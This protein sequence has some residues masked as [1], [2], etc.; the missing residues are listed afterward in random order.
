MFKESYNIEGQTK[1]APRTRKAKVNLKAL[2]EALM[3]G[4]HYP[5]T[6]GDRYSKLGA[7]FDLLTNC[8]HLT[9][10]FPWNGRTIHLEVGSTIT[11][12]RELAENWRWQV[13][14]VHSF[15]KTLESEG[16][17]T[18]ESTKDGTVISF[19]GADEWDND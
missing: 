7:Y 3:V 1:R 12:Y 18:V 2:H 11:S 17:I 6:C 14:E 4:Y 19:I 5:E 9:C 10:E 13:Y 16:I 8:T 15:I